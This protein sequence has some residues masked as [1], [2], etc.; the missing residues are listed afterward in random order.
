KSIGR[1]ILLT[2]SAAFRHQPNLRFKPQRSLTG[3]SALK[4]VL[5]F[6][7]YR[8]SAKNSVRF[9][10]DTVAPSVAALQNG[11]GCP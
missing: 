10:K 11:Q 5:G 3:L 9:L 1:F 6:I 8:A 7:I 4:T 2:A